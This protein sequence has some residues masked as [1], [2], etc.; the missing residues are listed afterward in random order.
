MY[1]FKFLVPVNL[2]CLYEY[3]FT[4]LKQ[5]PFYIYL[6]PLVLLLLGFIIWKTWKIHRP[7]CFG[8]LFFLFTIFPVLQ[9]LPVGS[10]VAAERYTYIPY[11]GFFI[12]AGYLYAELLPKILSP[13]YLN[14]VAGAGLFI[15]LLF[16]VMSWNRTQ[17]WKN[18]I[19]LW[20][21][22]MEKNPRSISAYVNRSY[23]YNHTDQ[24]D[25]AMQ[26]CNEGLKLEPDNFKLYVNR[27][28]SYRNTKQYGLAVKDYDRALQINPENWETYIDRG[29]I[30]TDFLS[31]FDKGIADFKTLLKHDPSHPDGNFNLG[32]A[33]LKKGVYDSSLVY[34]LKAIRLNP[35]NPTANYICALLYER[36]LDYQ[37]ACLYGNQA[38][39]LGFAIEDDVLKK[40]KQRAEAGTSDVSTKH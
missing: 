6:S 24:Y 35:K 20:T 8:V 5:V 13:K 21:D 39:L 3:P 30:Y 15:L 37:K 36:K 4:A 22:V 17:V 28:I 12:I 25:K 1:L 16:A 26:D 38:R 19:A 10:A 27:G 40:W 33:Y 7:V 31:D 34:T 9:F 14:Y 2:I 32:V 29:T 23:M 11:I 18:S